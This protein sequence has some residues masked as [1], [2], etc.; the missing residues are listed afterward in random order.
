MTTVPNG[1]KF[2]HIRHATSILEINHR[3]F[4]IDPMLSDKESMPAVILSGNKLKNPRTELPTNADILVGNIDYLLLTHLHFDHLDTKAIALISKKT[5]VLCP[6]FDF[7]KLNSLGFSEIHPIDNEYETDGIKFNQFP[8]VHG[9]G[10]LKYLMG[11]GS[12]YLLNYQGFKIF[13]TG[14]CLLT[15]S[16]RENLGNTRPDIVVVNAGAAR[17]KI[18][19]PITMSISDVQEISK[20]LPESKIIVVHLDALN[21]CSESRDYCMKQMQ[22]YANICIPVNGEEIEF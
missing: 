12:S 10:F 11:K 21:H 15:S 16:L 2:T 5:P 6:G 8:A 7:R 3:K 19:K 13:L 4:L 18:G 22:G 20:I 9:K 14:D 1:F 17:F